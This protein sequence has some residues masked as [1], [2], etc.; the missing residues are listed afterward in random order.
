M[1]LPCDVS[2]PSACSILA[3]EAA[4]ALDGLDAVLYVAG[5]AYLGPLAQASAASWRAMLATNVVGAALVT[6]GALPYLRSAPAPVVAYVSSHSVRRPW[7][8]LVPYA[9][10]K[11]A[12]ET[13]ALGLR[14]EEPWLRVLRVSV[15]PTIT[16]FSDR[17]DPAVAGPAFER[18]AAE[19]YLVHEPQEASDTARRIVAALADGTGPDDIEVIGPEAG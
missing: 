18:W 14:A 5:A 1:A 7:P 13:M 12:L 3:D 9:A 6:A 15:G 10:S 19:G 8:G 2:D 17:W 16:G 4:A 11:A